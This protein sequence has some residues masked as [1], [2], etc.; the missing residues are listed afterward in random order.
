[1]YHNGNGINEINGL[2]HYLYSYGKTVFFI[3]QELRRK[4]K[5]ERCRESDERIETFF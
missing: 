2:I 3:I 4:T 1:M 5:T